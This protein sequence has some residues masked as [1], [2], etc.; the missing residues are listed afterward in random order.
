MGI[1]QN[2]SMGG[3]ALQ[4]YYAMS[5]VPGGNTGWCSCIRK[6]TGASPLAC[7]SDDLTGSLMGNQGGVTAMFGIVHRSLLC[8]ANLN[9]GSR[10]S[11]Y[12]SR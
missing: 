6:K 8:R 1:L 5:I 3:F 2:G 11:S 10:M 7:S 4:L 9:F 12:L